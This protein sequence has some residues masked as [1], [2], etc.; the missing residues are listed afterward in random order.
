M[1]DYDHV[2]AL[3]TAANLCDK[4]FSKLEPAYLSKYWKFCCSVVCC[5]YFF[6]RKGEPLSALSDFK[7]AAIKWACLWTW[8]YLFS[9]RRICSTVGF[10][11]LN[12]FSARY[13]RYRKCW[14]YFFT[15]LRDVLKFLNHNILSFCVCYP[16]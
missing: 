8:I 3:D 11:F 15:F 16:C 7:I 4:V 13:T 6:L 5:L 14:F 9:R 2:S 1:W 12:L 10:S